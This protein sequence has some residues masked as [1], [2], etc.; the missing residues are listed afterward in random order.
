MLSEFAVTF[1]SAVQAS[2]SVLM[3][4]AVGV[5]AAQFGF[6]DSESSK[7][8]S[9]L[10]AQVFLPLLLLTNIGSEI[11]LE[12]SVRYLPILSMGRPRYT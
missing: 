12:T 3:T 10:S 11:N 6:L 2:L 1:L 5:A 8:V 9:Q 7:R 4:I